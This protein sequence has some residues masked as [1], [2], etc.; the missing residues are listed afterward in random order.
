MDVPSYVREY[1]RQWKRY[2]RF[3]RVRHSLDSPGMYIL[4]RKTRWLHD[5]DFRRGTDRQVQ[6]KDD[7][8]QVY[9][10]WPNELK[11]VLGSLKAH[12]IQAHGGAKALADRL[13]AMEDKT[14]ELVDRAHLA[15]TEALSG[16]VYDHFGWIEGRK[17]SVP[18]EYNVVS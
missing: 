14:V 3:L 4:E 8:R 2:D 15:E 18:N 12:D 6:L 13:D 11:Y 7:Y 16:E 10:V 9:K 1:E 5:Y 17:I